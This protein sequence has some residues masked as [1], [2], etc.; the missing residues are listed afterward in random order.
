MSFLESTPT[1]EQMRIEK[2]SS[3][4]TTWFLA[5]PYAYVRDMLAPFSKILCIDLN[6]IDLNS[7]SGSYPGVPRHFPRHPGT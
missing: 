5:E 4:G 2:N 1:G 6:S 7:I 3:N